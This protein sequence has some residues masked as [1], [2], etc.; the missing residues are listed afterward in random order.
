MRGA[1][2]TVRCISFGALIQLGR[3]LEI[4]VVAEGL[5][6]EDLVEAAAVLGADIGQGFALAHPMP[7]LDIKAWADGFRWTI[8]RTS[9]KSPLG[10]LAAMWRVTH[11]GDGPV[12]SVEICP[13][14]RF[15]AARGLLGTKLDALHRRLHVPAGEEDGRRSP[16]YRAEAVRFRQRLAATATGEG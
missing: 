10:M 2:P 4:E 6:S 1:C 15:I 12:T 16:R 3:D 9:P 8:D 11:A 13:I 5:E 14:T 7:G